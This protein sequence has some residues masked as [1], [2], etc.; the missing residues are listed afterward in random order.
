MKSLE[1]RLAKLEEQ[2]APEVPPDVR[3]PGLIEFIR[4]MEGPDYPLEKIPCGISGKSLLDEIIKNM[5]M[6]GRSLPIIIDE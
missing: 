1:G 2:M 3:D 5:P 4:M 6:A